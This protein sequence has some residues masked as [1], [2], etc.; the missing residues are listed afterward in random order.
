MALNPTYNFINGAGVSQATIDLL[1]GLAN[2]AFRLWG[3]ALAGNANVSVRIEI[4]DSIPSGRADATWGNGTTV[5]TVGG[6][7]L[8]VGAPA[9]ELM[10][11]TNVSGSGSDIVIRFQADYLLSE[12]FLDPTP[13]TRNDIPIDR[14][15][16]LSVLLHEIG[17]ALGFTGYWNEATNTFA[18]NFNTPYDQ[19]LV[20]T[21]GNASFDGPNVRAVYGSNVVLT[22]ENYTHYGNTNAYP[23]TSTDPLTGLMNGVVFYRGWGYTIGDL[24]LAFLADMGLGTI[25]DDI[26]NAAGHV[27]LRGGAGN[28]IITGSALNNILF[29]DDGNDQITGLDG[30]DTII[31]GI[32]NDFI[33]GGLGADYLI[34]GDGD[35]S[36]YG[37]TGSA[38][39]LQGGL[40]QDGYYVFAT[41]DSVIE[42][43]DEGLDGV[44][45]ALP[46][47]TLP[48]HV[49]SLSQS[50]SAAGAFLGIGN[51]LNNSISA[52]VNAAHQLYGLGGDDYLYGVIGTPSTLLGGAGNDI[53]Y[54]FNIGDS[55]IEV[56]GDGA[57]DRVRTGFGI[58]ALQAN[59]EILEFT[60]NADHG[61]GVGN[62][63]GNDI[64]GG[65]GIDNL[66]GRAGN[67]VLYGGTGAANTL[68]GQ[69]GDDLY[70]IETV[71]DS[72]VEFAGEGDDTAIPRIASY[73]LTD[74]VENIAYDPMMTSAATGIGNGLGNR[75]QGGGGDDF[76]SG[77]DGNDVLIG[78]NGN[79]LLLGG[80]GA[81]QFRYF[82]GTTGLD[83]ILDFASGTDKIGLA[84]FT[85]VGTIALVQGN[86]AAANSANST[87]LY[88]SSNGILS[89]DLD[90]NGAGA[91]IQIAQLNTGLSLTPGDFVFT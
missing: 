20:I 32:G 56:A 84:G 77:L 15:D 57:A 12:L 2:E 64:R 38:N 45:T 60:D 35:D 30:N 48:N 76:L 91:A 27:Y 88:N 54:V 26:L 13:Q 58:Y 65:T 66:Y 62:D 29:G 49:E 79:D 55:T 17:H 51:A 67:D 4:L 6:Y 80:N 42:F 82:A 10:T 63:I 44:Q 23:G 70:I 85:T 11:G 53:Y 43:A 78:L 21:N 8:A 7:G 24:D 81:D 87:I 47:Y 68:L 37:G 14:T 36:L 1:T 61:A 86:G 22:D 74:N 89:F 9:Y 72:V 31:G 39:V 83:R 33:E 40:G 59:I 90:G 50:L 52:S 3:N 46:V 28:D 16:G 69:E 25:R 73:A 5:G 18:S 75:L 71:G 41:G 19:R 34:G